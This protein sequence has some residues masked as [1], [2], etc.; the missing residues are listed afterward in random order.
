MSHR[1]CNAL[2]S[3][4]ENAKRLVSIS[5]MPQHTYSTTFPAP[6]QIERPYF[7]AIMHSAPAP[8]STAPSIGSTSM[9]ARPHITSTN[10]RHPIIATHLPLFLKS[11]GRAGY[12]S[13]PCRL[14]SDALASKRPSSSACRMHPP[15]KYRSGIDKLPRSGSVSNSGLN[16]RFRAISAPPCP[17]HH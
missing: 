12:H 17:L 9:Q 8:I 7:P 5:K 14:S 13:T 10:P 11:S 3:I 16:I 15:N 6:C 2:Y 4:A 1:K